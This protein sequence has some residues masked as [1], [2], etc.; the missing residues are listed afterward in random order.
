MAVAFGLDSGELGNV[1]DLLARFVGEDASIAEVAERSALALMLY[2]VETSQRYSEDFIDRSEN[3]SSGDLLWLLKELARSGRSEVPMVA[4]LIQSR[5]LIPGARSVFLDELQH[6]ATLPPNLRA[7]LA[8]GALGTLSQDELSIFGQWYGAGSSRVL[9]ASIFTSEDSALKRTAFELLRGKSI[10]DS[11]IATLLE[12]IQG[13]H[14]ENSYQFGPLLAALGLRDVIGPDAVAAALSGLDT[15]PDARAL[16][17]HIVKGAPYEVLEVV[18]PRYSSMIEP[19]DLI[20]LLQHSDKRA[21]KLALEHLSAV[22]DI[23]L[24]KLITQAYDEEKDSDVRKVYETHIS[25]IRE[26][27]GS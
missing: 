19:I 13:A 6:G 21:R 15:A 9:E 20:D 3:A 27:L 14:A 5:K 26:R 25:T 18:V 17:Q 7:A 23:L 1:R 22:N 4:Q 12:Y 8:A 24:V 16:L 2:V 11:Y 10:P